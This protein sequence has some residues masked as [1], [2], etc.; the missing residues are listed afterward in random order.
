MALFFEANMDL[1]GKKLDGSQLGGKN[2]QFQ[3]D[4]VN[5]D[6]VKID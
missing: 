6:Q 1:V 2:F 4:W 5:T 3:F